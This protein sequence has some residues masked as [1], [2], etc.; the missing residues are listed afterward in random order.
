M[1]ETPS[2]QCK[3]IEEQFLELVL[4]IRLS[5][6]L[7]LVDYIPWL[8]KISRRPFTKVWPY[9]LPFVKLM[10]YEADDIQGY[11]GVV[12][13]IMFVL[14]HFF[15]FIIIAYEQHSSCIAL[16]FS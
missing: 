14:C 9:S 7:S 10:S 3:R 11:Q 16:T 2:F 12:Q 13:R 15:R 8:R 1:A 6:V 5:K 4:F